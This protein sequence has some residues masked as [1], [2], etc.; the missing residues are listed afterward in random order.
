[1][2]PKLGLAYAFIEEVEIYGNWGRGFHS[3]DA[4]GVVNTADTV[5]GLSE[6]EG[7]EL[8]AR[9]TIA[10]IG[11]TASYW[12][13]NQDSELIFIGDS[14]SVEPKGGSRREGYELTLFWQPF[15]GVGIDAVYASSRA[16]FTDNPGGVYVENAIE[17]AAQIGISVVR[18]QWEVSARVRYLGPYA[19]TADNEHRSESLTTVNLRTA[20]HLQA[21][22]FYAEVINLL[23]SDGKDIAYY[24]PAY[25]GGLDAAGLT[26]GDIDCESVDCTMSRVTES[27]TLRVGAS[28]RF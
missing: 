6:G 12:W 24:Y 19:L 11:L 3:N 13:L 22:T 10:G 7:Y 2:T 25:I 1:M 20:Y 9:A 8:G 23:D 16:R 27:R 28:Y 17:E 15:D 18:N 4:R 21:I 26:S 14:N 5:P